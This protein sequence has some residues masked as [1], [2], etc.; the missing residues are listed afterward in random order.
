MASRTLLRLL[1]SRLQLPNLR[2][3]PILPTT[4]SLLRNLR[5]PLRQS[6]STAKKT[7]PQPLAKPTTLSARLKHL[8]RE[9]GYSAVGVYFLLSAL[10]FP[11]CFLAVQYLGAEKIGELETRV[12]GF[13]KPYWVSLR[14]A[15][16]YPPAPVPV[17]DGEAG[18]GEGR[19]RQEVVHGAEGEAEKAA[20]IW[21]EL[22]L[23]YAIHKSFIFIRVPLTAAVTP[24]VV[25]VMR[26]WG[27]NIGR[28]G[29]A[30]EAVKKARGGN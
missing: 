13:V 20:S 11:F 21:T 19:E 29:G 30:K 4:A 18:A 1:P 9:Y 25:K 17:G 3:R 2:V 12:G 27:W 7:P 15:I 6:F 14:S 10:D 5:Q 22:A 8:S 16:G 23:A 28:K 24:K 26:G